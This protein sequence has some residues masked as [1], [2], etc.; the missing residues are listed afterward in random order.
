M[1]AFISKQELCNFLAEY[2][3]RDAD[4][5]LVAVMTA[6]AKLKPDADANP[7]AAVLVAKLEQLAK[8]GLELCGEE[9]KYQVEAFVNSNSG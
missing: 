8:V 2:L 9:F 7:Y 1:P 5:L 3:D 4:E 6:C